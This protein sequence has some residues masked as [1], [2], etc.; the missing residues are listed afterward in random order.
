MLNSTQIQK[1]TLDMMLGRPPSVKGAEA[2]AFR[3][4]LQKDLDFAKAN[5]Y[6]IE[7]PFDPGGDE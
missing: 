2:D 7:L 5:G 6:Q 3:V 4:K 1:I